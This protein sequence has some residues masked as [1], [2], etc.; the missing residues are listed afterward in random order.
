VAGR[1]PAGSG[2][3]EG[4]S[5]PAHLGKRKLERRE[6]RLAA[7]DDAG[8][9]RAP[10]PRTEAEWAALSEE[11]KRVAAHRERAYLTYVFQSHPWRPSDISSA[12]GATSYVKEVFKAREFFTEHFNRVKELVDGMEEREFGEAF[13]LYLH[14]E[15]RLTFDKILRVVRPIAWVPSEALCSPPEGPR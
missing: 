13:G 10:K 2:F 1:S 12:L 5:A 7:L 4:R 14:Y 8:V 9:H 6:Q 15:M 3:L 11:S